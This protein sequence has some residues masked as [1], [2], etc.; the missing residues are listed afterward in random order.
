M[1]TFHAERHNNALVGALAGQSNSAVHGQTGVEYGEHAFT[2]IA[3]GTMVTRL[4]TRQVQH[5]A[6]S[7]DRSGGELKPE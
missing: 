1:H 4:G 2:A 7:I 3:V 5:C 6:Y